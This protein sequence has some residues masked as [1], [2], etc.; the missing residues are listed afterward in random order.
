MKISVTVCPT[1]VLT[2]SK[3]FQ[4]VTDHLDPSNV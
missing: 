4:G 3:Q 1:I 2:L